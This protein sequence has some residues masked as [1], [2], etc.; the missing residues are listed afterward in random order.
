MTDCCAPHTVMGM[1]AHR[2]RPP[3]VSFGGRCQ[4]Q[5][6][7]EAEGGAGGGNKGHSMHKSTTMQIQLFASLA[8]KKHKPPLQI[9][10]ILL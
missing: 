6:G 3:K 10:F 4:I 5:L 2:H 8:Y 1:L 9:G 7:K